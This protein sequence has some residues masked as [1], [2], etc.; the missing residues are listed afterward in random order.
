[1]E[2]DLNQPDALSVEN[3]RAFLASGDDTQDTQLR[4]SL[5]GKVFLQ[6]VTGPEELDGILFRFETWDA[7][8]ENVG[9]AAAQKE[10]WVK[11]IR[12]TLDRNWPNPTS[13]CPDI[14]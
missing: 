9:S 1:M 13:F 6:Q 10:D 3:V 4:V 12:A 11:A 8:N 7:G 2:L 5:S 14:W